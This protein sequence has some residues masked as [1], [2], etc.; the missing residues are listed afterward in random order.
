[1]AEPQSSRCLP[2]DTLLAACRGSC[3]SDV[4]PADTF[5]GESE[6]HLCVFLLLQPSSGHGLFGY[7]S[8]QNLLFPP[9]SPNSPFPAVY[10]HLRKTDGFKWSHHPKLPTFLTLSDRKTATN[11]QLMQLLQLL[12]WLRITSTEELLYATK[13]LE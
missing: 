7:Y 9:E 5:Q 6:V 13:L 1:M 3:T 8:V 11:E 10:S 12:L 2:A 4:T